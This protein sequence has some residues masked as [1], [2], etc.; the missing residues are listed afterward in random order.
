MESQSTFRIVGRKLIKSKI[1]FTTS[2]AEPRFEIQGEQFTT[3]ELIQL[4][5][6]NK[7]TNPGLSEIIRTKQL[8]SVG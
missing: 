6:E 4:H 7:L 8:K 2:D 3:K 5:Q 1:H